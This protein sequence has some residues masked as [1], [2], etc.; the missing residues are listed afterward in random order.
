MEIE[1]PD[2]AV[3]APREL[4][5]VHV[6]KEVQKEWTCAIC[7]VTTTSKITLNMHHKAMLRH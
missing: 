2:V 7:Q 6:F 3:A 5:D 4:P 1:G